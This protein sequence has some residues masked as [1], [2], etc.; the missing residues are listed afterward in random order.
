MMF[1]SCLHV[2]SQILLAS[3]LRVRALFTLPKDVP[4]DANPVI[5]SGVIWATGNYT[6]PPLSW[7]LSPL[8]EPTKGSE[9]KLQ[10]RKLLDKYCLNKC[11]PAYLTTEFPPLHPSYGEMLTIDG[12]RYRI[13]GHLG[14]CSCN[15]CTLKMISRSS[16]LSGKESV[17]HEDASS[18]HGLSQ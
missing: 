1:C 14:V 10:F 18:I 15:F 2:A 7:S 17:I 3:S 6:S 4:W 11:F 16:H 5:Q 12:L 13:D 8:A 9:E